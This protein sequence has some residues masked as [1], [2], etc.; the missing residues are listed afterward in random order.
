MTIFFP[1]DYHVHTHHS[2]DAHNTMTEMCRRAARLGLAEVAF[3]DHL[4]VHPRDDCSGF[5]RPAAFWADLEACR[6]DFPSLTIRAGVEVGEI[7]RFYAEVTPTLEAYPYDLVIGSLHWVGDDASFQRSYFE[8][9]SADQAA[10]DYFAELERMVRH[11]GF[12]VLGHFD[13]FRRY[14]FGFYG[15][16]DLAPYEDV[17]RLVLQGCVERGIALEINTSGLRCSLGQTIP[18][19]QVLRWY[20]EMGGEL[21]T[22]GSDAHRTSDLAAGFEETRALALKAGFTRLCRFERRQVVGWVEI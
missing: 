10:L 9:R 11:G 20:R 17:V 12:D 15:G 2:C 22:V 8:R 5:Y 19:L 4:D 7:H 16:L 6:A 14:G 21:L 3:T 13:F 18:N 1:F